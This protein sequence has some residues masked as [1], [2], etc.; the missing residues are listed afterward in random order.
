MSATKTRDV[1]EKQR[2]VQAVADLTTGKSI[3]ITDDQLHHKCNL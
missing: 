2:K 1:E 3:Q